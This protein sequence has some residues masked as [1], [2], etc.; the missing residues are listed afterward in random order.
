[1]DIYKE[2]EEPLLANLSKTPR[3]RYSEYSIIGY[4]PVG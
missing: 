3:E 2:A 4:V 1:M